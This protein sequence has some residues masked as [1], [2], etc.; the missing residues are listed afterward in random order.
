VD[1]VAPKRIPTFPLVAPVCSVTV[2]ITLGQ[3]RYRVAAE[4]AL[5]VLSAAALDNLGRAKR[6]NVEVIL[7][8]VK[9]TRTR[10]GRMG[11]ASSGTSV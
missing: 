5:V 7:A 10:P 11:S 9:L 3:F 4:V 8:P 6:S 2:A 1:L